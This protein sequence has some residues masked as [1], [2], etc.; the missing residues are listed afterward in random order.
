MDLEKA[1][2]LDSIGF[3]WKANSDMWE[4]MFMELT[5]FMAAH[6]SSDVPSNMPEFKRLPKLIEQRQQQ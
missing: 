2:L 5:D 4:R 1:Q 6:G 3:I